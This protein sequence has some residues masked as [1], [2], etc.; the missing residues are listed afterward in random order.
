[1][2]SCTGFGGLAQLVR[3]SASHAEGRRFESATLHQK[4]T[5]ILIES[6]RTLF[7]SNPLIPAVFK[8]NGP[9]GTD[10]ETAITDEPIKGAAVA[11][12]DVETKRYWLYSPGNGASIWDECCQ[13]GIMAIGWDAIG[14]LTQYCSKD[15]MKQAMKEDIDPTLSYMNAAHATWQF[16]NEM[17][18]GDIVFAKKG[19]H[20]IVGRGVVESGYLFDNSRQQYKNIRNV[21]WTH[22]G[23]WPHPGQAVMKVLHQFIIGLENKTEDIQNSPKETT[24][25]SLLEEDSF[26]LD[27]LE[28]AAKHP[29]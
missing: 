1:M 19:M 18:P 2:V 10:Y 6:Q 16:V 27:E 9:S 14:D 26:G 12:E 4:G 28:T 22:K 21:K 23:E 29:F 17:K 25:S 5:L 8:K 15:E 20:L 3:A 7:Y 13:K 24:G 11:D